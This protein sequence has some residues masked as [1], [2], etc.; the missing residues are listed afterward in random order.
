LRSASGDRDESPGV[1]E[2]DGVAY[3]IR[4]DLLKASL[5]AKHLQRFSRSTPTSI[6]VQ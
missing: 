5:V 4:D 2:L 1:G 6:A 3:K